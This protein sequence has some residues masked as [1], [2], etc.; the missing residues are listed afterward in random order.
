MRYRQSLRSRRSYSLFQIR[1]PGV[2]LFN[3]EEKHLRGSEWYLQDAESEKWLKSREAKDFLEKLTVTPPVVEEKREDQPLK[4][5]L[6]S[7]VA[8]SRTKIAQTKER[9]EI[10]TS[11][12]S[13][14]QDEVD[15]QISKAAQSLNEF[16][17]FG[18]GY[19]QGVDF[20]RNHLERQL[21]IFRKERRDLRLKTWQ[22]LSS[23]RKELSDEIIEYQD[24]LRRYRLGDKG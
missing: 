11:L 14:S 4:R 23:L 1:D 7:K 21:A 17:F 24:A 12:H 5:F 9:L 6:A 13:Q 15:Y 10:R 18:V 16:R 19:N 2:N 8:Q 22:D 20:K 3:L